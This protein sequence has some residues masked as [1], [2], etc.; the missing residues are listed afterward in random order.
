LSENAVPSV[1]PKVE[2][3]YLQGGF[4]ELQKKGGGVKNV[5]KN[6]KR[7]ERRNDQEPLGQ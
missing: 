3:N 2:R 5:G 1:N 6:P 4:Y 7:S